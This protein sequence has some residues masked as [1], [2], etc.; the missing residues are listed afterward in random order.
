M[1]SGFSVVCG[2]QV[3]SV[4]FGGIDNL[5]CK[6]SFLFGPS[7]KILNVSKFLVICRDVECTLVLTAIVFNSFRASILASHK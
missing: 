6:Y 4:E 7:W 5:Y 3:E 2:G 1:A